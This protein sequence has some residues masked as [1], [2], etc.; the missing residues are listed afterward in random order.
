[1]WGVWAEGTSGEAQQ[2]Q[3]MHFGNRRIIKTPTTIPT[4]VI[5]IQIVY[6]YPTYWNTFTVP[7]CKPSPL[8]EQRFSIVCHKREEAA[9]YCDIGLREITFLTL[10][11]KYNFFW[12]RSC[13]NNISFDY[14]SNFTTKKSQLVNLIELLSTV[15]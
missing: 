9:H 4:S 3:G 15:R 1:M 7:G 8:K 14:K 2:S 5:Q 10:K 6:V 12:I 11:R 13:D